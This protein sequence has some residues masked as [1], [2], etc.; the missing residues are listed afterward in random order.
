MGHLMKLM[1]L[2]GTF[3]VQ[4]EATNWLKLMQ[5]QSGLRLWRAETA[6]ANASSEENS[7]LVTQIALQGWTVLHVAIIQ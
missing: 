1:S 4:A 5:I 6:K 2:R 3:G 7:S